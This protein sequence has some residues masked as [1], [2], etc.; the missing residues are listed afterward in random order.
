MITAPR[1]HLTKLTVAL[2]AT[3]ASLLLPSAWAVASAGS[4]TASVAPP[5][6]AATYS[7]Q[8]TCASSPSAGETCATNG[9]ATV[10]GATSLSASASK[11]DLP[12]TR[13]APTGVASASEADFTVIPPAL[14]QPVKT[15][16]YTVT[17]HV[18]SVS[19]SYTS[20]RWGT[21]QAWA[22]VGTGDVVDLSHAAGSDVTLTYV[23]SYVPYYWQWYPSTANP[24]IGP[25]LPPLTVRVGAFAAVSGSTGAT[26]IC[27]NVL[28]PWYRCNITLPNPDS[29]DRLYTGQGSAQVAAHLTKVTLSYSTGTVIAYPTNVAA[30]T[31]STSAHITWNAAQAYPHAGDSYNIYVNDFTTLNADGTD[32]V[33]RKLAN[34]KQLSYTAG[35]SYTPCT[36]KNGYV[37]YSVTGVLSGVEGDPGY[38]DTRWCQ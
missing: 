9:S 6:Q 13:T 24:L 38:T 23:S 37:Q 3:S 32:W 33:W 36:S 21:A 15:L 20:S 17:L 7:A 5:W 29:Y 19:A 31:T 14:S 26:P 10:D 27:I 34:T 28:P 8:T 30:T 4:T 22:R 16:T 35:G 11:S 1:P 25:S 2:A 18:D 12:E